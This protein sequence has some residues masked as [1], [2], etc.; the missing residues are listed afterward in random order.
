M[1][2]SQEQKARLASVLI[3]LQTAMTFLPNLED[4]EIK[5]ELESICSPET[6]IESLHIAIFGLE[7]VENKLKKHLEIKV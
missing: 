7:I 5:R 6:T 3:N 2:R 4:P 1:I